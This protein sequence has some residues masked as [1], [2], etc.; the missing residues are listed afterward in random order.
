LFR[1]QDQNMGSQEFLKI[2]NQLKNILPK[3]RFEHSL[4]VVK[5][6]EELAKKHKVPLNKARIAAL[7]HD[8]SRSLDGKEYLNAAKRHGIKIRDIYKKVPKLV[9]ADLA[10]VIARERFNIKDADILRAIKN[11]TFGRPDMGALEKIIYLADHIEE[12]R[13]YREAKKIR[14]IAISD[15]NQAIVRTCDAVLSFLIK[16]RALI[17]EETIRTR[18]A[19]LVFN[20]NEKNLGNLGKNLL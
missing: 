1:K 7:L 13:N 17:C 4:R 15:L 9:H 8:C 20:K 11:H 12:G 6:A 3:E 2:K 18:N 10:A 5:F 14:K 16:K 19:F